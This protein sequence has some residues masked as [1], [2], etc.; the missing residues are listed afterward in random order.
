[1]WGHVAVVLNPVVDLEGV[2]GVDRQ[3]CENV[4][5]RVLEGKT[6]HGG[7]HRGAREQVPGL[8]SRLIEDGHN[9]GGHHQPAEHIEKDLGHRGANPLPHR[10]PKK[11]E[12]R[13]QQRGQHKEPLAQDRGRG[14]VD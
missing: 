3:P 14:C 2:F 6:K 11:Q 7:D 1:M 12:E 8:H 10:H 4:A 13:L 5:E 9:R